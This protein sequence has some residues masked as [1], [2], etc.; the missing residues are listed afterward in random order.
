MPEY[1]D[2]QKTGSSI[3]PSQTIQWSVHSKLDSQAL[4]DNFHSTW[5]LPLQ[6]KISIKEVVTRRRC[7]SHVFIVSFGSNFTCCSV[8]LLLLLGWLT[9]V[10]LTLARSRHMLITVFLLTVLLRFWWNR[11]GGRAQEAALD[12][13]RCATDH[14]QTGRWTG[15]AWRAGGGIRGNPEN[16]KV[17]GLGLVQRSDQKPGEVQSY[18]G[19]RCCGLNPSFPPP[20]RQS[21]AST[22]VLFEVTSFKKILTPLRVWNSFQIPELV[23]EH[24]QKKVEFHFYNAFIVFLSFFDQLSWVFAS[25]TLLKARVY[26]V[27]GKNLSK[28]FRK[29]LGNSIPFWGPWWCSFL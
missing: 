27:H 15:L 17:S 24:K 14:Q 11:N 26:F 25:T 1:I 6:A 21:V 3:S 7:V 4:W 16:N 22:A 2:N 13:G 19:T 12:Q 5:P 18:C 9:S 28:N 8:C 23:G 10:L 20:C 29:P